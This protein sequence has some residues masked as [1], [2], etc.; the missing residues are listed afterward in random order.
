MTSP[1]N[2]PETKFRPVQI[3]TQGDYVRQ[4]NSAWRSRSFSNKQR[5][6]D[7]YNYLRR[8]ADT[9]LPHD[10]PYGKVRKPR[11]PSAPED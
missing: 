3:N 4:S 11:I 6:L 2:G 10:I 8:Q 7:W 9:P 1:V 5:D